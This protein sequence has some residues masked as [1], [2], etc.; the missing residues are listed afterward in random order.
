MNY[1][2][3]MHALKSSDQFL[4]ILTSKEN[5]TGDVDVNIILGCDLDDKIVG[6]LERAVA[7]IKH[8]IQQHTEKND[9]QTEGDGYKTNGYTTKNTITSITSTN[10]TKKF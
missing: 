5:M 4:M 8:A 3:V 1:N 9:C 6:L 2:D 10:S 7:D